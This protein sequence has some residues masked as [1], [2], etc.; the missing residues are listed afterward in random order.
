MDSRV[1]TWTVGIPRGR[2]GSH[3]DS[4]VPI[5]TVGFPHGWWGSHMIVYAASGSM[6]KARPPSHA[7][8]AVPSGLPLH[9]QG[10]GPS[11]HQD[12]SDG[13]LMVTSAGSS[14]ESA[15][16]VCPDMLGHSFLLGN[17]C[18]ILSYSPS[19]PGSL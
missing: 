8:S 13:W 7:T 14:V 10:Q 15:G 6:L 19:S 9:P 1:P 12:A 2:Q 16:Y 17:S 11:H 3:V 18:P 4:R 5:W